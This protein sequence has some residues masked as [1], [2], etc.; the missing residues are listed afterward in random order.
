MV[1]VL[2]SGFRFEEP[3]GLGNYEPMLS[4]TQGGSVT[5]SACEFSGLAAGAGAAFEAGYGNTMYV[6]GLKA[7]HHAAVAVAQPGGI[8][9]V[10]C[11]A[12][13]DVHDNTRGAF[14]YMGGIILLA[15]SAT[16]GT[17]GGSTNA[18]SGGLIVGTN[19]QPL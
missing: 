10:S 11:N 9:S 17:L 14:V 5:V 2:F 18:N 1:P 3:E 15:G 16:P 4:A 7:S 12:A 6:S 8:L 19:G 13:G